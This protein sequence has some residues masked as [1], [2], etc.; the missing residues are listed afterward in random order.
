MSPPTS[1]AAAPPLDLLGGGH[2]LLDAMSPSAIVD[3]LFETRQNVEAM[4]AILA[5]L[6]QQN[7]AQAA[8]M[9]SMQGG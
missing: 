9:A 7:Q 6:Q 8:A 4:T 1:H 2:K 5:Q 3:R